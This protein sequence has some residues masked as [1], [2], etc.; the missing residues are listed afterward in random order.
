VGVVVGGSNREEGVARRVCNSSGTRGWK[1][2]MAFVGVPAAA[3]EWVRPSSSSI[4][5][6]VVARVVPIMRRNRGTML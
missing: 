1:T 3:L 6:V 5:V 4:V 2:P